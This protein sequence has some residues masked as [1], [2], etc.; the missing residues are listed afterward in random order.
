MKTRNRPLVSVKAPY[1]HFEKIKI[2]IGNKKTILCLSE[3]KKDA[4]FG[5]AV[6]G[7][8]SFY[9]GG[10]KLTDLFQ[11]GN[12]LESL[13]SAK[14]RGKKSI[15]SHIWGMRYNGKKVSGMFFPSTTACN[16]TS[17]PD[18]TEVLKT[19]ELFL[20]Y[21][22]LGYGTIDPFVTQPELFNCNYCFLMHGVK[23]PT[24]R[25]GKSKVHY[26]LHVFPGTKGS[27]MLY[28]NCKE[29]EGTA[30]ETNVVPEQNDGERDEERDDGKKVTVEVQIYR[31]GSVNVQKMTEEIIQIE[32]NQSQLYNL[33]LMYA[34]CEVSFS[35]IC[36]EFAVILN[37][38]L[39]N[40]ESKSIAF[41]YYS[42]RYYETFGRQDFDIQNEFFIL[43]LRFMKF[44]CNDFSRLLLHYKRTKREMVEIEYLANDTNFYPNKCPFGD[45]YWQFVLFYLTLNEFD[46]AITELLH[47]VQPNKDVAFWCEEITTNFY[48]SHFVNQTCSCL[49]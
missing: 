22:N 43:A 25:F 19:A 29:Q 18:N 13:N 14:F 21:S 23:N 36:N 45:Y 49:Q 5:T 35:R 9:L 3:S 28:D 11:L 4:I 38:V 46:A 20:W 17:I 10:A 2:P 8:Y 47:F 34:I 16:L 31:G 44:H 48:S 6:N 33:L 12:N 40:E 24:N 7:V 39:S 27:C 42:C 15:T 32:E 30:I 37:R 26:N 1:P 41:L